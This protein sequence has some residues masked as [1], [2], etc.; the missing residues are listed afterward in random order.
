MK[1]IIQGF[2]QLR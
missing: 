1:D 2:Q